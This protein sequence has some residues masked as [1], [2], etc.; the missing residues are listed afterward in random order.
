[1]PV[2]RRNFFLKKGIVNLFALLGLALLIISLLFTLNLVQQRQEVRKFA[3]PPE[4]PSEPTPNPTPPPAPEP[5]ISPSPPTPPS[6]STPP[7]TPPST[8]VPLAT[9]APTTTPYMPVISRP[10]PTSTPQSMPASRYVLPY[11]SG[12]GVP[13]TITSTFPF[14]PIRDY[15]LTQTEE[16][17]IMIGVGGVAALSMGAATAPLWVP[18]AGV[19]ATAL[20]T[21]GTTAA[22][23][24]GTASTYA[25]VQTAGALYTAP[26]LVQ[27]AVQWGTITAE[28]G[29]T[30]ATAYGCASGN[31]SACEA[32]VVGAQMYMQQQV[33][34]AAAA[35]QG[36]RTVNPSS[37]T[38]TTQRTITFDRGMVRVGTSEETVVLYKGMASY[39]GRDV[40]SATEMGSSLR[41]PGNPQKALDTYLSYMDLEELA[42]RHAEYSYGWSPGISFTTSREVAEGFAWRLSSGTETGGV[43]IQVNL[44][45]ANVISIPDLVN[46]GYRA[47]RFFPGDLDR[48]LKMV[49]EEQEHI[50]FG[51]VPG[52]LVQV[53]QSGFR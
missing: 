25:Y 35:R 53:I 30:A 43:L 45:R 4:P 13:T 26:P 17:A 8:P 19:A 14:S 15:Q 11:G 31:R 21:A 37:Q 12:Y 16:N 42:T 40:L 10:I 48:S 34:Q 46:R 24:L 41:P 7:P 29:G 20:W 9:S 33:V 39:S 32:G 22:G 47:P 1:M 6:T 52:D 38:G 36:L 5:T 3:Y 49:F 50:V 23:A 27:R 2:V 51:R 18:A 44:P 28:L